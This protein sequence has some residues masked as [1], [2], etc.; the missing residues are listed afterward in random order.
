MRFSCFFVV[1]P[2]PFI[3]FVLFWFLFA[4]L[5]FKERKRNEVCNWKHGNIE[6]IW[7]EIGR[8]NLDKN[9]LYEKKLLSIKKDQY[10]EVNKQS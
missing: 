3:C 8:R 4:C 6:M 2:F 10:I 1:S 9:T 5:L 7:E